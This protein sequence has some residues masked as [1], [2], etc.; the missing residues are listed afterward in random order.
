MENG[1]WK[2]CNEERPNLFGKLYTSYTL[3]IDWSVGLRSGIQSYSQEMAQV[4][5]TI[6]NGFTE[7]KTEIIGNPRTGKPFSTSRLDWFMLTS[8]PLFWYY[9]E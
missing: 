1:K 5:M 7:T 2:M 3:L 9:K 4:R 6:E 8:Q